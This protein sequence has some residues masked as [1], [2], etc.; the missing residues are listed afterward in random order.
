MAEKNVVFSSAIKYDG[1][2]NFADF[3]KFCYDYLVDELDFEVIE[4]KYSE[5]ISGDSKEL[6]VEWNGKNKVDDYFRYDIKVEFII[7]NM[8]KVEVE[9]GGKRKKADKGIVN[10]KVKGTV[11]TDYRGEY[12][13]KPMKRFVK[14]VY[15]KWVIPSRIEKVEE[16]LISDCDDF[17]GQSKSYLDLE[18]KK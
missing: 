11:V 12:S 13:A 8:K 14:N 1:I 18:G 3:Y 15:D 9:Q 10:I 5:K 2:L 7:Y 4:K 16:K 6:E 17:L